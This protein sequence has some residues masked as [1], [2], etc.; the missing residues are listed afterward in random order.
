MVAVI[1]V[2]IGADSEADS[3]AEE[4]SEEA[5]EAI[6]AEEEVEEEEEEAGIRS[7]GSKLCVMYFL[8]RHKYNCTYSTFIILL[9]AQ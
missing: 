1:E 6:E 5:V 8:E 3:E 9:V 2:A 4:A 7:M